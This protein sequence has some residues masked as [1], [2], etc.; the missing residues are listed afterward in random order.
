MTSISL[1]NEQFLKLRLLKHFPMARKVVWI[2]PATI[3]IIVL[4]KNST[5]SNQPWVTEYF[6]VFESNPTVVDM[7]SCRKIFSSYRR[8][9]RNIQVQTLFECSTVLYYNYCWFPPKTLTRGRVFRLN[10]LSILRVTDILV[11]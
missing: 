6:F 9:F 4:C 10:R 11:E 2:N 5:G 3:A 7:D 8:V 1:V